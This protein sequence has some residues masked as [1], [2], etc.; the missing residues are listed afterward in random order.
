MRRH[1]TIVKRL[2]RTIATEIVMWTVYFM[3]PVECEDKN[4]RFSG[5][6]PYRRAFSVDTGHGST[7]I[8]KVS[9]ARSVNAAYLH[10]RRMPVLAM[11]FVDTGSLLIVYTL[12]QFIHG[13][14]KR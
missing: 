12:V 2:T 11:T 5:N 7:H 14:E 1:F 9:T 8:P 10:V 6:A 4:E 13:T 3:C